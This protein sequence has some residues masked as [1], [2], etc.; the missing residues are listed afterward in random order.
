MCQMT[1]TTDV[2]EKVFFL[3]LFSM[4]LMFLLLL[5]KESCHLVPSFHQCCVYWEQAAES[6]FAPC[7][8]LSSKSK[9]VTL[10]SGRNAYQDL[11]GPI[12][13][14][15]KIPLAT[16]FQKTPRHIRGASPRHYLILLAVGNSQR[17][18]QVLLKFCSDSRC[19]SLY[20]HMTAQVS[21]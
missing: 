15:L 20:T 9:E 3:C 11:S 18:I 17:L 16:I 13:S 7:G 6:D 5:Q 10:I 14:I 4:H 2:Q 1:G 19:P 8:I 12:L 21:R